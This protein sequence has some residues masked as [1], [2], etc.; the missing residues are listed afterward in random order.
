ME[1]ETQQVLAPSDIAPE[2]ADKLNQLQPGTYCVHRS[3]GTGKIKSWDQASGQVLIDFRGKAGHPMEFAYAAQSLRPLPQDHIEILILES[4]EQARTEAADPAVFMQKVVAGLKAEATS[5]RIEKLLCPAV[6][7]ADGWKKWWESAKRAMKKDPRFVVPSRK[8]E[9]IVFHDTPV[10]HQ[11]AALEEFEKAVGAK[12]QMN[13]LLKLAKIWKKETGTEAAKAVVAAVNKTLTLMPKSQL[14]AAVE[15]VLVRDEF[16]EI[17]GLPP[18]EGSMALSAFIPGEI[19]ALSRLLGQLPSARQVR[20]LEQAKPLLGDRWAEVFIGLLPDAGGRVMETILE[21]FKKEDRLQDLVASFDRLVRERKLNPDLLVWLCK[22]RDGEMNSLVG[23][24]LFTSIVAV[25]E[26]DQLA[27]Y[28]KGTKL[29][30]L[31]VG[32]K[33]LVRD[34]LASASHEEVR[35]I[36]RAVLLSPVFEELN[37]RSL[38]ATLVKLYPFV[39]SMIVGENKSPSTSQAVVV[40]WESLEKRRA[41]LEE[42]VNKKIPEN[43]KDIATARSYGDLRENHEFKAAKEMQTV[44]MRRK[45]ELESMLTSAQGTDFKGVSTAEVNIGTRVRFADEESGETGVYTILGAWDSD[46]AAGIISYLTPVAQALHRHAVGDVVELPLDTGLKR[47]VRI[48]AI[49]PYAT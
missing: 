18:A 37:K 47:R 15:L 16:M 6:I 19:N 42:L 36:T 48:T 45:A 7:P 5:E 30:D 41:E 28:K 9:P 33:A 23:P 17:S 21:A 12:A 4:P 8:T 32:D 2:I 24:H 35:D 44:L 25:L 14:A 1:S 40:S 3:W 26:Y 39:Q 46:P 29:H 13:G 10:D 49:E 31:L 27:D 43:S 11:S 34:L 38:L 22:N 20:F